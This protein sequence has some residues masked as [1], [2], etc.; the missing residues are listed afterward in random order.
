MA[1]MSTNTDALLLSGFLAFSCR[2]F[3]YK[4]EAT[5]EKAMYRN[6]AICGWGL[7]AMQAGGPALA[8][9]RFHDRRDIG[10]GAA[11]PIRSEYLLL[12]VPEGRLREAGCCDQ[13]LFEKRLGVRSASKAVSRSGG[14]RPT[15][16]T[17]TR[18][19]PSSSTGTQ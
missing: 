12:P 13:A 7:K 2:C 14:R 17:P 5:E 16:L 11:W 3:Y 18:Y 8:P 19:M 9:R 15:N 10:V 4:E 1:A 6:P